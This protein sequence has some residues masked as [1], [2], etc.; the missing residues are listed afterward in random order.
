[1]SNKPIVKVIMKKVICLI[2]AI[3]FIVNVEAQYN[4]KKNLGDFTELEL[5]GA[6]RVD[7]FQSDSNYVVI[8]SRDSLAKNPHAYIAAGVLYITG[9]FRGEVH[10]KNIVAIRTTDAC[11][12]NSK[13][14]LRVD[15]L[16]LRASDAGK[17]NILVN[18]KSIYSHAQDGSAISISGTTDIFESKSSDASH[19]YASGLKASTVK[20]TASDGSSE[21]IWAVNSI[22]ARASDGS[23]IH[24]KGS[25]KDKNTTASDGSSITMDDSGE[26]IE[27][28]NGRHSMGPILDHDDSIFGKHHHHHDASSMGDAFI[29][30]GFVTGGN[31]GA[32]IKYGNSREVIMGFGGGHKFCKWDGLGFDVYYKSTDFY[33][34]QNANKTFPDTLKH[35]AQKVSLQNFGGLIYDRIIFASGYHGQL[36]LDLGFY[37]DWTFNLREVTWDNIPGTDLFSATTSKSITY[38]SCANPANYGVTARLVFLRGLTVYFNYRLS[39][40]LSFSTAPANYSPTLPPFVIGITFGVGD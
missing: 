18:A 19:L 23:N 7:L 16:S 34:A 1:M 15:K 2:A 6:S 14:T 12:V 25:P 8:R 29:G 28:E 22:D 5:S 30:F 35:N 36:S 4:V 31:T 32:A 13:D 40:A 10:A 20:T 24:V 37:F 26:E 11:L 17:L 33:L 38:L 39:N 27:P 21:D 3:V 9:A